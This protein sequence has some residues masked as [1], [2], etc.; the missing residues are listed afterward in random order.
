VKFFFIFFIF[1]LICA[2]GC[3]MNHCIKLN[4]EYNGFSG[5]VEYCFSPA[6]SKNVGRPVVQDS[7]GKKSLL[8]SESDV[9][10]I[11]AALGNTDILKNAG[12]SIKGMVTGKKQ[13]KVYY[14]NALHELVCRIE[15]K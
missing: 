2:S 13:K 12:M 6:Q 1:F 15:G 8:L 3:G 7:A 4:G 14:Q 10:R 9:E 11:N 5:G